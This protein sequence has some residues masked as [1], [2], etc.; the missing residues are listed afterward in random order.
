MA[1]RLQPKPEIKGRIN[2]KLAAAGLS[3]AVFVGAG[4]GIAACDLLPGFLQSGPT[5]TPSGEIG[6]ISPEPS[7][8]FEIT[9]PPSVEPTI[10]PSPTPEKTPTPTPDINKVKVSGGQGETDPGGTNYPYYELSFKAITVVSEKV[11]KSA[12]T[13]LIGLT[14]EGS[15]VKVSK[16]YVIDQNNRHIPLDKIT[17]ETVYV[18]F[19]KNS[20][21]SDPSIG[22]IGQGAETMLPYIKVGSVLRW[23]NIDLDRIPNG[24]P[25]WP[26]TSAQRSHNRTVFQQLLNSNGKTISRTDRG[27]LFYG[28]A[29]VVIESNDIV[30][31]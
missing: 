13:I 21:L 31:P 15:K 1:E 24:P 12:G 6:N 30:N 7:V 25:S 20:I 22:T 2:R 26:D 18:Q 14:S 3:V 16:S 10:T 23:V 27:L 17:G 4:S 29:L 5:P 9:P 28:G 11:N 8:S 19:D